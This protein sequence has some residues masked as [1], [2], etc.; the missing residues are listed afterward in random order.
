MTGA[1]ASAGGGAWDAATT[2]DWYNGAGDTTFGTG[3]TALFSSTGGPVTLGS[4]VSALSAEFTGG[5]YTITSTATNTLTFTSTG[6]GAAS[7]IYSSGTPAANS[8]AGPVAFSTGTGV[9]TITANTATDT[10]NFTGTIAQAAGAALTTA[11]LGTVNYSGTALAPGKFNI[12]NAVFNSSGAVTVANG[13]YFGIDSAT[14]AT[15][16][17]TGGIFAATG[18]TTFIGAGTAAGTL[19]LAGGTNTFAG[20]N[21]GNAYNGNIGA[22]GDSTGTI[23]ITNGTNTVSGGDPPWQHRRGRGHD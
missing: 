18:V 6:T 21:V 2:A 11:G 19:N 10:L 8:F 14:G 23:T 3:N 4:V 16:N 22:G 5:G 17:I 15:L 1:G 20:L 9:A 12:N 13:T 7:A